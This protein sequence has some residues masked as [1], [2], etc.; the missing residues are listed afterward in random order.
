[1]FRIS[2]LANLGDTLSSKKEANRKVAATN[3]LD[4][5]S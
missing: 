3:L 4:P 5:L 2:C 1:M